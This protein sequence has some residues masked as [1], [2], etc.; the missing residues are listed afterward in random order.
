M[1][2][3]ET[4]SMV[5]GTDAEYLKGEER[6][7]VSTRLECRPAASDERDLAA[8]IRD[9]Q[10]RYVIVGGRRFSGPLYDA[11]PPGG[12]IARFGVGYDGIDRARATAARL[13]CTNAPGVLD[14]S[15]A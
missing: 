12:V 5:L 10:V 14:Q 11:L 8:A 7:R 9:L 6:F 2:M 3:A 4:Q 1:H 15:V 13:F